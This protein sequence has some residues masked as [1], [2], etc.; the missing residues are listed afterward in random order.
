MVAI[1]DAASVRAR[2][3][4]LPITAK[5]L[6]ELADVNEHTL[7]R[8]LR[9]VTDPRVSTIRKIDAALTAEEQRVR[10]ELADRTGDAA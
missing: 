1:F 2:L 3:A 10:R 9:A 4:N 5:Q 8:A 7:S 6:A